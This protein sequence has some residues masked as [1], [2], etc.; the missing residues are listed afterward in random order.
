[1]KALITGASSGIGEAFAYKLAEQGYD[2]ILTGR[3][4]EQLYKVSSGINKK[5]PVNIEI[6]LVELA[7]DSGLNLLADKI[8]RTPDLHV[9]VNN[10]GF[11]SGTRFM[12]KG[13]A[14][15]EKMVKVHIMA[16][17]KLV[18]ATLPKM[19]ENG[20]GIII[21]VSSVSGNT[22]LLRG[23]VYSASKSF[24]RIF[25]E[26][27]YLENIHSNIIIQ[28]LCPGF[29]RTDF[30]EKIG[31]N[32][33]SLKNKGIL[34]WMT[35]EKVVDASF[36]NLRKGKVVCV[37]GFWNKVIWLLADILPRGLYYKLVSLAEKKEHKFIPS[38]KIN[39]LIKMNL[40]L[41]D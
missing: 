41:S 12:E 21:N 28:T 4:E 32:R 36:K 3:R 10:A 18:H 13:Y 17:L 33:D 26:A 6:F 19:K 8:T 23:A 24:L 16:P 27:L 20:S 22:P 7:D 11:G 14:D 1:M 40:S 15:A 30:H 39:E 37:P 2:L 9:L 31:L 38:K 29:T 35:P 5:Y 25:S 34:R